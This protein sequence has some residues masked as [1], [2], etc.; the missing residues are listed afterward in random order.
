M[1]SIF[2]RLEASPN[3]AIAFALTAWI[4]FYFAATF[5][6]GD[7]RP[8]EPGSEKDAMRF[9]NQLSF[10]VT[11]VRVAVALSFLIAALPYIQAFLGWSKAKVR[12]SLSVCI[13]SAYFVWFFYIFAF[14]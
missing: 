11:V 9:A 1:K 7:P 4:V 6:L 10:K 3:L 12:F 8:P 13:S 2:K 14:A 5:A